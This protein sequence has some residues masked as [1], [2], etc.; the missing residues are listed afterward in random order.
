MGLGPTGYHGHARV[1]RLAVGLSQRQPLRLRL[2]QRLLP[3]HRRH[4]RRR[5][6]SL[7]RRLPLRRPCDAQRGLLGGGEGAQG[8]CLATA[9]HLCQVGLSRL[10]G[11]VRVARLAVGLSQRQPLRLRLLQRLLP[12][13]RRHRRHCCCC[14]RSSSLPLRRPC[15][16]QRGLLG[17]GE[18]AQVHLPATPAH[19]RYV[20]LRS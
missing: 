18:A 15:D 9:P 17:G 19:Q 1:T 12:R 5:C 10:H 3:R 6:L 8:C 14:R 11:H 4:R 20:G 2:L 7:C 16:A 13:Q